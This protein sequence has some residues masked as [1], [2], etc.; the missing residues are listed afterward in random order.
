MYLAAGE[1]RLPDTKSEAQLVPLPLAAVRVL[2]AL[3]HSKGDPWIM[4]SRNDGGYLADLNDYWNPVRNRTELSAVCLHDLRHSF[5][6]GGLLV[7]EGLPMIYEL[8]R[9]TQIQTTSR[10]AHLANDPVKSAANRFASRITEVAGAAGT[11]KDLR[12]GF[13]GPH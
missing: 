3:P 9:H 12:S 13:L 4:P 8:P 7:V 1:I 6:S 11:G 2:S 5:A 10:Y